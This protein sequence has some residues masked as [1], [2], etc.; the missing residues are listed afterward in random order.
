MG[1][2]YE[3][4]R[5]DHHHQVESDCVINT[6]TQVD[7]TNFKIQKSMIIIENKNP[8]NFGGY[9]SLTFPKDKILQAKMNLMMNGLPDSYYWIVSSDYINYSVTWS[10]FFFDN[11]R[12]GNLL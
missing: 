11:F 7:A 8:I 1:Q 10:C 6:Y 5:Y 9:A 3:I 4:S 12:I 2:W